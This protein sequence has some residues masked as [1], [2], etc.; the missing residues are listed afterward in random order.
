MEI[1]LTRVISNTDF[2]KNGM[3]QVSAY[4]YDEFSVIDQEIF[5]V[6][7]TSPV[8]EGKEGGFVAIPK[9]GQLCTIY[10][11]DNAPYWLYMNSVYGVTSE[12]EEEYYSP[13][14]RVFGEFDKT[15]PKRTKTYNSSG[16]P[17]TQSWSTRNGNRV[18]FCDANE[19]GISFVRLVSQ[20]GKQ[21]ILTDSI[22]GDSI[23]LQNEHGDRIS[24]TSDP[25]M[26]PGG[27][28]AIGLECQGNIVIKSLQGGIDIQ[29][30]GQDINITNTA[31]GDDAAKI[32]G[33]I[34]LRSYTGD[35]NINSYSEGGQINLI[36]SD[37]DGS[38]NLKA[39]GDINLDASGSINLKALEA[40]NVVTMD[41][42]NLDAIDAILKNI[43][44]VSLYATIPSPPSPL[45]TNLAYT[46]PPISAYEDIDLPENDFNE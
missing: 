22:D 1:K 21:I 10:K 40:I 28:R 35:V 15:L 33:N 46:E 6:F 27:R 13:I 7:Y 36:N 34:N 16:E 42:F 2:S 26:L 3:L 32:F 9:V 30:Q 41:I 17:I 45:I 31:I 44:I 43:S 23:M 20:R 12:V 14:D 5:T 29:T 4:E 19:D 38:I 37:P 24:I 11:P 25:S 39:G 8:G 18:E